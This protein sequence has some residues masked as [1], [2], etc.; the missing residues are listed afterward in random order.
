MK[1]KLS[2]SEAS[3]TG[4]ND[5]QGGADWQAPS[6]SELDLEQ[7]AVSGAMG[8]V[9]LPPHLAR[10]LG[11]SPGDMI[12]R[13]MFYGTSQASFISS[14]AAQLLDEH[15]ELISRASG[16]GTSSAVQSGGGDR[17]SALMAS[18]EMVIRALLD[19]IEAPRPYGTEA[20][21]LQVVPA[22]GVDTTHSQT[23]GPSA[24]GPSAPGPS[25][26][27]AGQFAGTAYWQSPVSSA[28]GPSAPGAEQFAGTAYWQLPGPSAP[29]PSAPGPSAPGAEQFAGT[30][31]WQSP[32]SSA[33][34]PSAPGP[35]AP[36]AEQFAGTAYWQS[37]GPSAPGPSAP[38]PSA[39][40][41]GQFAG[42]AYWQ[43]PGPSAPGP[44]A[45]GAEQFAGTAYW[46]APGLGAPGPSA[47][48]AEQFA[49]TAYWQAPGPSAPG[50]GQFAGTAYW[51]SPGSSAPGPSAPGAEQFAGTAY[52]QAP[53]PGAPGPSAPVAEQFAAT[54]YWQAPGPSAPEQRAVGSGGGFV[55]A[56]DLAIELGMH[57]GQVLRRSMFYGTPNFGVIL[58]MVGQLSAVRE[59]LLASQELERFVAAQEGVIT[60]TDLQSTASLI[61]ANDE[62]INALI[63]SI[64]VPAT[65]PTTAMEGFATELGKKL[66]SKLEEEKNKE[67]VQLKA[68]LYAK[69]QEERKK[70]K[71]E[72]RKEKL[73]KEEEVK[74]KENVS[75]KSRKEAARRRL[76]ELNVSLDVALSREMELRRAKNTVREIAKRVVENDEITKGLL[77][78]RREGMGVVEDAHIMEVNGELR[79]VV[80]VPAPEGLQEMEKELEKARER[81]RGLNLAGEGA[82]AGGAAIDMD[83]LTAKEESLRLNIDRAISREERVKYLEKELGKLTAKERDLAD[84]GTNGEDLLGR[85]RTRKNKVM[86]DIERIKKTMRKAG[87]STDLKT[88]LDELMV[89]KAAVETRIDVGIREMELDKLRKEVKEEESGDRELDT[90]VLNAMLRLEGTKA[91]IRELEVELGLWLGKMEAKRKEIK[92]RIESLAMGGRWEE[93][94]RAEADEVGMMIT[95][96]LGES[97]VA[98]ARGG[99]GNISTSEVAPSVMA[100]RSEEDR[101]MAARIRG[102]ELELERFVALERSGGMEERSG[103]ETKEELESELGGVRVQEQMLGPELERRVT[104]VMNID[105]WIRECRT[106]IS[107]ATSSAEVEAEEGRL[108]GL[109]RG[110]VV[111]RL[112]E[113]ELRIE[114]SKARLKA[115]G[116]VEALERLRRV[117]EQD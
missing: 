111:A 4:S 72:E 86:A 39:P 33:P 46:Q 95:L 81:C 62:L 5:E 113:L 41:A 42:T 92:D 3:N 13:S 104:Y 69:E 68:K 107:G 89:R 75:S 36:G 12:F 28:P 106:M 66:L 48:V 20:S 90:R 11:M 93:V 24:P 98:A 31:Y 114:L 103:T 63:S 16:E 10:S 70:W 29:G 60:G 51:Q 57:P 44:S 21:Q 17:D 56:P 102:L 37:P 50:A 27:G 53:G 88:K 35:S 43:S 109:I 82:V 7:G 101:L 23:P 116:L 2:G 9:I 59:G 1:R 96:V 34:G 52:W 78:S 54:A 112:R 26:P 76:S 40:G 32:G 8:G 67:M 14:L 108:G 49:A 25:A 84:S 85:V 110:R 94:R 65:G 22:E 77:G 61:A 38:G 80:A 18:N 115:R 19:S 6:S 30:A 55:L 87:I 97:E 117:E 58:N 74:K 83:D 105:R 100:A 99:A 45:P 73:R 91:R 64:E 15:E 71:E 79:K 47:P